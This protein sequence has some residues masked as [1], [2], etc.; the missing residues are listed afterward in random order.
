MFLVLF[1]I[2]LLCLGY[3]I[4]VKG[5]ANEDYFSGWK[6]K[7]SRP[8]FMFGHMGK[9]M[10]RKQPFY[11]FIQSVYDEFPNEKANG[12]W[13]MRTPHVVIRDLQLLKRLSVKEFDSFMDHRVIFDE[14]MDS[15]MGNVLVALTGNKWR[16]MRVTLS[17]AFTGS[18]MRAMFE[19]VVQVSEQLTRHLKEKCSGSTTL[20]YNVKDV[21]SKYTNDV[22]ALCA[23]GIEVDSLKSPDNE[24]YRT[25][26]S[27]MT[28]NLWGIVKFLTM[29]FFPRIPK[30]LKIKVV[31]SSIRKF[32]SSMVLET[33][34]YREKNHIKRPDMINLLMEAKKGTL[35]QQNEAEDDAI[36]DSE[37]KNR[38]QW[39]DDEM[40]AQC[41]MFFLAGFETSAT[42]MT[43]TAYELVANPEIQQKLYEEI[44]GKQEE[45]DE[46]GKKISY[47]GIKSLKYLDMV[48]SET[49]RKWPPAAVT[50]RV[51]NQRFDFEDAETGLELHFEKGNTAWIPIYGFHR[52]PQYFPEPEKFYPERFSEENR[53]LINP[54]AYMPFGIGPRSCIANRFALMEV[55][56]LIYH[57]VLNFELVATAKTNLPVKI[58][59]NFGAVAADIFCGLKERTASV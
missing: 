59:N 5:R 14:E 47:D 12:V 34:E 30:M 53:H 6:I 44:K 31:S 32:F 52:D 15:L 2:L 26:K 41:L 29:R 7:Y 19:L 57:L 20:E 1:V 56:A 13:D 25:G 39:T 11:D 23:F 18:K 16:Q 48:V 8:R 54:D 24:F 42:V 10:L 27:L 46:E 22:I 40:V 55:K 17:P 9:V 36:H 37:D 45:L 51:C 43:V 58:T 49:L 50:D 35:H 28:P 33:M 3:F 21:C 4:Y 38:R